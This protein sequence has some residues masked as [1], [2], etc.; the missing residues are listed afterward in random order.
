VGV[1]AFYPRIKMDSRIN[2]NAFG[3]GFPGGVLAGSTFSDDQ[4]SPIPSLAVVYQKPD[5]PWSFGLGALGVSGFGVDF[6]G[7]TTNPILTPQR[8]Q[9]GVGFGPI[10]SEFQL[11]Q[12]SPTVALQVTP[13]WSIGFAPT[14][15]WANLAI[16]PFS[17]TTPNPDGSYPS[18]A[19]GDSAWGMGFQGGL[20]YQSQT[21][22]WNFGLS[23]KSPQWF[24]DFEYSGKDNLG[25]PRQFGIDL[26]YPAIY[27]AGIAYR[28]F[29]RV[30]WAC[31]VR[32][33]DYENTDG[34][35]PAGFT[36]TGA[37]TG[38]GWS[39]IWSISTGVEFKLHERLHWR[40]GYA[41]NQSP[42]DSKNMFFN[43]PAPALIQH[44]LSTG[45][46]CDLEQGWKFSMTYHHGLRN[47]VS[48][49]WHH[50]VAGE[51]S[52]TRITTSLETHN[53][54]LGFSKQF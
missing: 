1:S 45:F 47:T 39:S 37:V 15:N 31:D 2:A 46:T 38:F 17:A 14:L 19:Q 48:G 20:F 3:P 16:A 26:D 8:P 21:T 25:S 40:F 22:G 10:F 41:F 42:I 53:L 28:G 52:G 51:L 54:A 36:N 44:H 11:M 43:S 18:A 6:P 30:K 32:Y 12:I 27:S 5:S 23:Y 33:I 34:F 50:P 29:D 7:S 24:Q 9:G 35:Q 4:I 13:E 49:S